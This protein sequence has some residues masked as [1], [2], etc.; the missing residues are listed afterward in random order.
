MDRFEELAKSKGL[1]VFARIDHS[2]GAA[3][4]G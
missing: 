3:K 2:A 1:T 4:I